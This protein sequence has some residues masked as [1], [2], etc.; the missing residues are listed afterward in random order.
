[1]ICCDLINS[2]VSLFVKHI[3]LDNRLLVLLTSENT[4]YMRFKKLLGPFFIVVEISAVPSLLFLIFNI[5]A[6]TNFLFFFNIILLP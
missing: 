4:T 1:M 5:N 6:K 3:D 2:D